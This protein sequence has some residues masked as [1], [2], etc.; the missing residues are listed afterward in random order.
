MHLESQAECAGSQVCAS[1]FRAYVW[2]VGW[3]HGK[4]VAST[5][6]AVLHCSQHKLL[7]S[8]VNPLIL[9]CFSEPCSYL[10]SF[11]WCLHSIFYCL[12]SALMFA[13]LKKKK[14]NNTKKQQKNPTKQS[15][16]KT[17]TKPKNPTPKKGYLAQVWVLLCS[18]TSYSSLRNS[19]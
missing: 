12:T 19:S 16:K 18:A 7:Q 9:E 5:D 14:T 10:A 4:Y 13:I 15:N 2:V 3:I 6:S 1:K 8:N 17:P 11:N